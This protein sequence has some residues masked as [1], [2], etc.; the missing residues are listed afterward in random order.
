LKESI[1]RLLK[2]RQVPIEL[3]EKYSRH[4]QTDEFVVLHE[5]LWKRKGYSYK[6]RKLILTSKPRLIYFDGSGVY[7]GFIQW[8]LTKRL[9]LEKVRPIINSTFSDRHLCNPPIR[10]PFLRLTTINLISSC[11]IVRGRITSATVRLAPISG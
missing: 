9:L 6:K 5:Y 4:I 11:T 8:S 7:K 2:Q 10:F 1:D 3:E